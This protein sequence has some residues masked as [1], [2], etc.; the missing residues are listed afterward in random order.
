MLCLFRAS[1][2]LALYFVLLLAGISSALP[3]PQALADPVVRRADG[4]LSGPVTVQTNR[5]SETSMGPMMESCMISLTPIDGGKAVQVVKNCTLLPMDVADVGATSAPSPSVD[6]SRSLTTLTLTDEATLLPTPL[7]AATDTTVLPTNDFT[8]VVPPSTPTETA[9]DATSPSP[10]APANN[11][12]VPS[13]SSSDTTPEQATSTTDPFTVS[14]KKLSVLPIGL[15]VFAGISVIA[16]I[17]VGLVTYERTKY[18]KHFRRRKLEEA[19]GAM[20]FGR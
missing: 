14:G 19:A 9:S 13:S 17:I 18:R 15:G 12:G 11:V 3:S 2:F 20:D 1:L 8:T 4:D 6:P 7:A 16:L 5:T 10:Q